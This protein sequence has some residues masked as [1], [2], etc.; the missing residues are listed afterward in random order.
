MISG[1]IAYCIRTILSAYY[2]SG[3]ERGIPEDP[4]D[5]SVG[6]AL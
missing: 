5:E 4:V 2:F 1:R 6:T 3:A